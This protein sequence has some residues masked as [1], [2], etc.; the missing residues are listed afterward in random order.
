MEKL[1]ESDKKFIKG[2]ND[3]YTLSDDLPDLLKSV[4]GDKNNAE[5]PYFKGLMKGQKQFELD[6]QL[7]KAA[8][9]REKL[10][11]KKGYER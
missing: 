5:L 11:S 10:K 6:K 2:F 1:S 8:L 4:I 9:A 3:G 7:E